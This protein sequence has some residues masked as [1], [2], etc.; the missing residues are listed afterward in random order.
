MIIC[1]LILIC[2][3]VQNLPTKNK[4][5]QLKQDTKQNQYDQTTNVHLQYMS[6][7]S[8]TSVFHAIDS[9][10]EFS[11]WKQP[12]SHHLGNLKCNSAT[13]VVLSK[14]IDIFHP[15]SGIVGANMVMQPCVC[16]NTFLSLR[17]HFVSTSEKY[18]ILKGTSVEQLLWN[19]LIAWILPLGNLDWWHYIHTSFKN[20]WDPIT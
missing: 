8:A 13:A 1:I 10:D 5:S 11:L 17:N 16:R 3:S 6:Y 7:V 19:G 20:K 9:T 12:W 2:V 14:S 18:S 15:W 4:N